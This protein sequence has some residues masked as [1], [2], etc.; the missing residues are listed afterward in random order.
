M[1]KIVAACIMRLVEFDSENELD[2][3]LDIL[4]KNDKVIEVD[5]LIDEYTGHVQSIIRSQYNNNA[6][7]DEKV[8]KSRKVGE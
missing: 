5:S 1:K 8:E 4:S 7:L 3:Y 2:E 6:F